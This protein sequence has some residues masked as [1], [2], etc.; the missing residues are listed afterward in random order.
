MCIKCIIDSGHNGVVANLM[1]NE[2]KVYEKTISALF[3][4][5]IKL[6]DEEHKA[7]IDLSQEWC[8]FAEVALEKIEQWGYKLRPIAI[9]HSFPNH[10][11]KG[12]GNHD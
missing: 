10:P 6:T 7:L 8:D 9:A 12:G 1:A 11:R 2:M 5:G 4:P 3:A